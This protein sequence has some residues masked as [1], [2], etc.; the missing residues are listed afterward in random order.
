MSEEAID[1]V[2]SVQLSPPA[3]ADVR[4]EGG[5]GAPVCA[6]VLNFFGADKTV[7]C[8]ESLADQGLDRIIVVDNSADAAEWDRLKSALTG[9]KGRLASTGLLLERNSR[10][11][12]FGRAINEALRREEARDRGNGYYL[13]LNNDT[14]V[15]PEAVARLQAAMEQAPE[16]ALASPV[17][18][19]G[20]DAYCFRWYKRFF[21]HHTSRPRPWTFPY[22]TGCCLLVR[23]E[24]ARES[25]LFDES[26]FMYGED[27]ELCWRVVQKGG[28]L[29]CV[30]GATVYHE[31]RGSTDELSFFY[32]YQLPRGQLLLAARAVKGPWEIPLMTLGRIIYLTARA[33]VRSTRYRSLVPAKA[34]LA[35]ALGSQGPLAA[36]PVG[37]MGDDCGAG[38]EARRHPP[39]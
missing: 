29:L 1:P 34:Y 13:L 24:L 17:I 35:A 32:E 28:R 7:R 23:A 36:G 19:R 25:P 15:S 37:A 21:G 6:V 31:G 5:D 3:G 22:L 2:E 38:P 39:S 33:V 10:N 12:G 16:A 8:L 11:L 30:D 4:R 26:F 9:M 27:I 14:V 20:S 18:R